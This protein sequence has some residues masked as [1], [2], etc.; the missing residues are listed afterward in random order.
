MNSMDLGSRSP[1]FKPP[2]DP[3]PATPDQGGGRPWES[4]PRGPAAP[5]EG[6]WG[7]SAGADQA[8]VS[9]QLVDV[10]VTEHSPHSGRVGQ[11][12]KQ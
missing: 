12:P 10:R 7:S 2:E 1:G 4:L 5:S 3:K 11:D 6:P 9:G 8:V